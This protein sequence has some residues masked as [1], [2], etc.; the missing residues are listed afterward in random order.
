MKSGPLA[1]MGVLI[2]ASSPCRAQRPDDIVARHRAV[3]SAVERALPTLRHAGASMDRLGIERQSTEGGHLEAYCEGDSIRLL[4]AD[5]YGEMADV[6]YR[7]YLD[8]DSLRF[9]FGEIRRGRPSSRDPYPKRTIVE[10]E[11]LYF[12]GDRLIRWL[13]NRNVP[14]DA[15]STDAGERATELLSDVRGFKAAMPACRPRYAPDT[16]AHSHIPLPMSRG[17]SRTAMFP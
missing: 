7:F 13:G 2:I 5:Y 12:S 16:S 15:A 10:Q 8:H 14:Q 17:P 1:V 6:T 9:V 11:R 4:V 3:Y